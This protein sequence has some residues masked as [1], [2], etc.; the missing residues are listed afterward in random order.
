M[1]KDYGQYKN[2]KTIYSQGSI[3]I[4]KHTDFIQGQ[5]NNKKYGQA[6]TAPTHSV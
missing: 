6:K 2:T 1:G 3:T 5:Q 4:N